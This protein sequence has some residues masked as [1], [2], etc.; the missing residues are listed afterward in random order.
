VVRVVRGGNKKQ[1]PLLEAVGFT[2]FDFYGL[3]FNPVVDAGIGAGVGGFGL[4]WLVVMATPPCGEVSGFLGIFCHFSWK[5]GKSRV[6]WPKG[7]L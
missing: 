2:G 1:P 4:A 3:A 7:R 6:L 5:I